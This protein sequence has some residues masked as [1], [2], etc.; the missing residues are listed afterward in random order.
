[1]AGIHFDITADN[2][3]FM[4]KLKQVQQGVNQTSKVIEQVGKNFDVSTLEN[5]V[6]SLNRVIK[7]NET[8]MAAVTARL[9][10][11]AEDAKAAFN[12]GDT[13]LFN[14]I[15]KDIVDQRLQ[16]DKL[17]AE[18][19]KYRNAL[20]ITEQ[21]SGMTTS[22]QM[23]E[24]TQF[25]VSEAD[26][27]RAKELR[28]EIAAVKEEIATMGDADTSGLQSQLSAL[29]SELSGCEERA[30]R[31]AAELGT[32]LGGRAAETS[33]RLYEL[34]SAVAEQSKT[35]EDLTIRVSEAK[36]A[37]DALAGSQD[38]D[39]MDEASVRYEVLSTTLQNAKNELYNLQAAQS[40]AAASMGS[41][42][43]EIEQHNSI[44]VKMLG[45]QEQF[46]TIVSALPE[47][48]RTVAT[49][50]T[51]MTGAAKAFIATPL[52]AALAAII[53]A[54]KALSTWFNSTAEG[55]TKFA[56]ISGYLSGVLGQ[57]KEVVITVGK[58]I[59]TA[60]SEPRQAVSDLWEAIKSN[61]VTRF[62]A[63]GSMATSLG[64]ALQ[65]AFNFDFEE[66]KNQLKQVGKSYVDSITGIKN[67]TDK[68]SDFAANVKKA[69]QDTAA[70]AVQR[71]ELE[72]EVS[73][74]A[75]TKQELEQKIQE[76]SRVMYDTGATDAERKKALEDYK[77]Y[78][79]EILTTEKAFAQERLD[80]KLYENSITS[81]TIEDENEARR[82]QAE[83]AALDTQYQQ[84]MAMLQRRSNSFNRTGSATAGS[85]DTKSLEAQN[86]SLTAAIETESVDAYKQEAAAMREYLKEYGTYQQQKLAIAE[87]YAEKIRQA[88]TEGEKLTL[89]KQRDT[90]LVKLQS[91]TLTSSIDWEIVFGNFGSM[92]GEVVQQQLSLL[93][94]YMNTDEFKNADK[95]SQQSLVEAVQKMQQQTG[96]GATGGL[97]FKKL[98]E[99]IDALRTALNNKMLA[100]EAEARALE[101]LQAAQEAYEEALVN[102]T[103]EQ[104][105]AAK[106]SLTNAESMVTV[107]AANS[108]A[109]ADA[110][111]QAQK[112]VNTTAKGLEATISTVNSALQNLSS[113]SLK[114]TWDGINQLIAACSSTGSAVTQLGGKLSGLIGAILSILDQLGDD[115]EAFITDLIDSVF[116]AVDK[117]LEQLLSGSLIEGIG[118]SLISGVGSIVDTLTFGLLGAHGNTEEV[119]EL[120][121]KL[122][123]S[124]TGLQN[125]IETLTEKVSELS[126]YMAVEASEEAIEKQEQVIEQTMA[127]LQEQ[128]SEY[129]NHHSNAYYWGKSWGSSDYASLN[130]A[131]A[132]YAA[133][134]GTTASTV[135][136]LTDMYELTP[137][138]LNYIRS[139]YVDLWEKITT[140]GKYDKSEYWE[141]YADLADTISEITETL[142]ESLTQ[143]SFDTFYDSFVDTL[144][145]MEADADDFADDF[146]TSLMKAVL[147]AQISDLLSEELEDFYDTWAEYMS[148][149]G[150]LSEQ[151]IAE[152]KTLYNNLVEEGL[153]IRD[154]VAEI[155]G[156]D[157]ASTQSASSGAY[158]TMS[159]DTAEELSGRFTAVQVAAEEVKVQMIAGVA[160]LS[161]MSATMT[162]SNTLLNSILLQTVA[163][164]GYLEDIAGYQKKINDTLSG[165]IKTYLSDIKKGVA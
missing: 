22:A 164:N 71:K 142:Q 58:A 10:K 32:E 6:V 41:L 8:A 144:M 165:D 55:Q 117:I 64:K 29:Q 143:T 102:G 45:G 122:T 90:E 9:N 121:E 37:L 139:Y 96:E 155:T 77:T 47:P 149:D 57:L 48:I 19:E 76:A 35:V 52:G 141:A 27:N 21:F 11:Y 91:D 94:E 73:K 154:Y 72:V 70:I 114:G 95:A 81:S 15:N 126:G 109:T 115:P 100:E 53:L 5:R 98:G 56:E 158:E 43:G 59:Y 18:T 42:R 79:K 23:V 20:A 124:N 99:D 86:K 93:K 150:T 83:L 156:Y 129:S 44:L 12:S 28:E 111:T 147:N 104:K 46:N 1:M 24:S 3:S 152:L 2:S 135:S 107:T 130:A 138:E 78:A 101:Q 75:T 51:G 50:I 85:V 33:Q 113:G 36:E 80:L 103:D 25:F 128:M 66:A 119:E 17:T 118:S 31:A 82:L 67:T 39:A 30:S 68:V 132:A 62:Q 134:N 105:K 92:F 4:E 162:E 161:V 136:S 65:A 116:G 84:R 151:E 120:T 54:V 14:E 26:Y 110:A 87:E 137:E 140:T 74:W 106:E 13:N 63:V 108:A 61:I 153:S 160:Y 16:L 49:S 133:D 88:Q 112:N 34:N 131:L 97:Q 40:D 163:M 159:Q 157:T 38:A 7:D 146:S 125:S 148:D 89:E 69:A 145:D 127:I 60:F 123:N